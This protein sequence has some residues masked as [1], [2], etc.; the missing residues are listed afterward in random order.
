MLAD[1]IV[2]FLNI[3]EQPRKAGCIFVFAGREE[4]K[5]Y[6]IELWRQGYAPEL[7]LSVGRF[8]WRRFYSLGLPAD[9]GLKRLVNSTP[10]VQRH[11]FV[12]VRSDGAAASLITIGRYGTW[13]EAVALAHLLRDNAP[14]SMM[15]VSSPT[16]LR[17]VRLALRRTFRRMPT[18]LSFVACPENA[19]SVTGADLYLELRKYLRYLLLFAPRR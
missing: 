1:R 10:P 8:E 4:R 11:F 19:G 9:G 6:G 18:R 3:G 13:T 16:H 14:E 7:I 17:R 5:V 15:V 2:D 12:R